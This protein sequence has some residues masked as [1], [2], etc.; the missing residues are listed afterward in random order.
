MIRTVKMYL[1]TVGI[2]GLL[3][4]ASAALCRSTTLITVKRPE[5]DHPFQLRSPSSDV[6]TYKHIFRRREYEFECEVEPQTILD[7]GANSGLAS[8]YFANRYP[9]ARIIAVEP[10]QA[11]YDLL[12]K[13]VEPYPQVIPVRAALWNRNET[14]ELV[15]PGL[16]EWGYMT[17]ATSDPEITAPLLQEVEGIT[18][19]QLMER[20]QCTSIDLMKLNVEGAEREIFEDCGGWIDRVHAVVVKMHDRL[21]PGC[22]SSVLVGAQGFDREWIQAGSLCRSRGS[23]LMRGACHSPSDRVKQR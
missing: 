18:V 1:R 7:A 5:I 19:D 22:E 14:I 10:E 23:H 17:R 6:A 8:I 9:N 2:V 15:D 13:N 4:T 21:K 12:V 3:R 20:Y 16:G 11:N